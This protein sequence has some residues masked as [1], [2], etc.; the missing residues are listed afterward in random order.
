MS[1][2][3]KQDTFEFARESLRSRAE[4]IARISNFR[5][6]L[7]VPIAD[8]FHVSPTAMGIQLLLLGLVT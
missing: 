4:L 5:G 2:L 3:P 7:F 1:G 8:R 6:K